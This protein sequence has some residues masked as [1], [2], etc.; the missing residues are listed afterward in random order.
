[1]RVRGIHG[2]Q[3][4]QGTRPKVCTG[5]QSQEHPAHHLLLEKFGKAQDVREGPTPTGNIAQIQQAE[6][7][8]VVQEGRHPGPN[9][10]LEQ[11]NSNEAKRHGTESKIGENE[12]PRQGSSVPA[13]DPLGL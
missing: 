4:R 6:Q 5:E 12:E 3:P 9:K 10:G 11:A 8:P 1:M 13:L 2:E 7:P